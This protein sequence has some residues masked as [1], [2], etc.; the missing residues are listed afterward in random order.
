[1]LLKRPEHQA[2]TSIQRHAGYRIAVATCRRLSSRTTQ[3]RWHR[4]PTPRPTVH[5]PLGLV[6]MGVAAPRSP[7][8]AGRRADEQTPPPPALDNMAERPEVLVDRAM[9]NA[10]SGPAPNR[11]RSASGKAARIGRPARAGRDQSPAGHRS[12]HV[13]RV[14]QSSA[15]ASPACLSWPPCGDSAREYGPTASNSGWLTG[16]PQPAETLQGAW[17]SWND[18]G[19]A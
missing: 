14:D 7:P 3:V 11:A 1:M 2:R 12:R 10:W 16:L 17:V 5:P 19:R 18:S 6:A 4:S 15:Q 13:P 9:S 8:T